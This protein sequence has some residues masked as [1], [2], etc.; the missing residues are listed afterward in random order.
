MKRIFCILSVIMILL[1]GFAFV[2]AAEAETSGLPKLVDA[3]GVIPDSEE[4]EIEQMLNN[5]SSKR[6]FDVVILTVSSTNGAEPMDYADDFYDNNNYGYGKN[7]DGVLLLISFE[8][9]EIWISTCGKGLKIIKNESID[10]L[11]DTF[12]DDIVAENYSSACKT[13][14]NN[15]DSKVS[16]FS[17][18]PLILAPVSLLIGFIISSIIV[19]GYKSAH[20]TVRSKAEATSYEVANSLVL[21]NR[22]DNFLYSNVARTPI[23]QN[24]T[25]SSGGGGT[26]V[27]SSGTTHGGGGR[28]F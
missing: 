9:R 19:S 28:S 22:A 20:K 7:R 18:R 14:A 10:T 17:K 26:H 25:R 16:S 15:V 5:I 23:P 4:A 6:K 2:A 24:N 13:F 1:S 8:P 27:S 21:A 3:A 12:Y 11:I